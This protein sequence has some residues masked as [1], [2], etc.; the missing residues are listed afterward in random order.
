MKVR[1]IAHLL[2]LALLPV[3][4][5]APP[6]L[7]ATP[8]NY[9]GSATIAMSILYGGG[10]KAF[11][12][13]TRLVFGK[14]D[15]ISGQ[16]KAFSKVLDGT[17]DMAGAGRFLSEEEKARGLK[18]SIIAWDA[19]AIWVNQSNPVADLTRVQARD[20]FTG[21]IT[22]WKEAGGF[23]RP[24]VLVLDS[25]DAGKANME[26]AQKILLE[27]RPFAPL[28]TPYKTARDMMA[29]VAQDPNAISL[30]G[31]GLAPTFN[32]DILDRIKTV[33]IDGIAPGTA[34][35]ESKRYLLTRPLSLVTSGPPKRD[36]KVFIDF[37]LSPEGQEIV[38]RD[39]VPAAPPKGAR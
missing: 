26:V 34:N 9:S 1:H 24:I 37:I 27:N 6:A 14:I 13:K 8:L 28:S 12:E 35:I 21:K 25:P 17:V 18:E 5:A 36:V 23:D 7:A 30:A 15:V 22:N 16:E 10:I 39:F 29:A 19:V 31:R 3:A 32:R 20:I 38:S 11:E 33:A 4:S 2:L